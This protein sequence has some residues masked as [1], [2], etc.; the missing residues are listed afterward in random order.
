[1]I[2]EHD[3]DK[4]NEIASAA[5]EKMH[6]LDIAPSP[7][8]FEVWYVYY[9]HLNPNLREE[10]DQKIKTDGTITDTTI[11]A[12]YE[13]YISESRHQDLYKEA[14]D[15]IHSTIQDV[16][17]LVSNVKEATDE[18]AQTLEGVNKKLEADADKEELQEIVKAVVADTTK[19][20]ND[21]RKLQEQL[22]RSAVAMDELKKDLDKVRQEAMTDGLTG[23]A[24]R[25]MLDEQLDQMIEYASQSGLGFIFMIL[26]IDH[27]KAFNDNYGHQVGDQVL[28]LVA[29]TLVDGVKGKDLVARYGGEEF[30]ILLP[31]TNIQSGLAVADNLRQ[32]VA[33]K[34]VINRSTG[35]KLGQI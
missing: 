7:D 17:G 6:K 35:E 27:F 26:D 9:A 30:V 33:N 8:H 20:L 31:D 18:Y 4:A 16:S 24:N 10:I 12:L 22:E 11:R 2:Y 3:T 13:K 21:N 1:M 28:R 14:G 29:R 5:L 25:K 34:E 32:A 23:L 19:M 15:Q